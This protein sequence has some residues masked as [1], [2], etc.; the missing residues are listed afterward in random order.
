TVNRPRH[1]LLSRAAF[2][3]DQNRSRPGRNFADELRDL[4]HLGIVADDELAIGARLQLAHREL[5][6][7]FNGICF[8][9]RLD[10]IGDKARCATSDDFD[11]FVLELIDSSSDLCI[12]GN[13]NDDVRR[14]GSQK[15]LKIGRNRQTCSA[16]EFQPRCRGVLVSDAYN[17]DVGIVV[18]KLQQRPATLA[19]ADNDEPTHATDSAAARLCPALVTAWGARLDGSQPRC[20]NFPM[21]RRYLRLIGK[22]EQ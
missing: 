7:M 10:E 13:I 15:L 4:F 14:F 18:E 19:G 20:S 16:R 9:P 1:Q 22:L 21:S 6:V 12:A 3:P 5:I 17:L 11:T 8:A 2:S